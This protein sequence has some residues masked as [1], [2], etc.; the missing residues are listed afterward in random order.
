M[1]IS[2]QLAVAL[3]ALVRASAATEVASSDRQAAWRAI[4]QATIV[5]CRHPVHPGY[6]FDPFHR[7][8]VED[9]GDAAR[10][11]G[12]IVVCVRDGGRGWRRMWTAGGSGSGDGRWVCRDGSV[13]VAA[14]YVCRDRCRVVVA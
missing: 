8:F 4:E 3:D 9:F 12:A 5:R 13:V 10:C 11:C 6:G 1:E 14:G 7:W 2:E